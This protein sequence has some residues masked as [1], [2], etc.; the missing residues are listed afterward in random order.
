MAPEI[1]RNLKVGQIRRT[2]GLLPPEEWRGLDDDGRAAVD[3]LSLH[4]WWRARQEEHEAFEDEQCVF[5]TVSWMQRLFEDGGS[6][7]HG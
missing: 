4:I 6:A 7:K 2:I 3:A 1:P 5:L